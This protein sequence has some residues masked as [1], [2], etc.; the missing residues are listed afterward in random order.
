NLYEVSLKPDTA[1]SCSLR[2]MS[3]RSQLERRSVTQLVMRRPFSLLAMPVLA[4]LLAG[5]SQGPATAAQLRVYAGCYRLRLEPW[6]HAFPRTENPASFMP[7]RVVRLDTIRAEGG[8][9][10][11]PAIPALSDGRGGPR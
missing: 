2:R 9:L 4:A 5:A 1:H 10:L 6:S 8:Y 11:S 3:R 7:P